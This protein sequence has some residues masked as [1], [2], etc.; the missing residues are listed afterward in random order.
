MSRPPL[1]SIGQIVA[2]LTSQAEALAME[3]LPHGKRQGREWVCGGLN[4]NEGQHGLSV[5][6][7]GAKQGVWKN[8]KTAQKGGDL[9]D[10]IA[11]ARTGGDKGEALK[12]A[13][14][15]LGIGFDAVKE[16]APR[17]AAPQPA[18][19]YE[20]DTARRV[21]SGIRSFTQALPWPGTPVEAYLAGRAIPLV[22]LAHVPRA[23]RYHPEL[24]W[25]RDAPPTPA[26]VASIMRGGEMIGLHVTWL[27]RGLHGAWRRRPGR[28]GKR[29]LGRQRGGYIPLS[30]GASGQPLAKAPP[31]DTVAITEGIEDGLT[32]ALECPDWR[33]LAAVNSGNMAELDLPEAIGTV[34]LCLQRDGENVAVR[35]AVD[36]AIARFTAE[37][38]EVRA[39]RPPEGFK[40]FNDWAQ[41][42][43][44]AAGTNIGTKAG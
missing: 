21:Q 41:E 29:V 35:H 36:A 26:M 40:D 25:S 37:G 33:V 23:L 20:A 2:M 11:Q 42:T 8:F 39:S 14:R 19:D 15:F 9:L 27:E 34:V 32:I 16:V 22:G 24:P 4:A 38:R 6:I 28:E 31:G 44:R 7:A 17:A 5:C 13:R 43:M 1:H 12:W 10:L 30:R 3:L 18:R